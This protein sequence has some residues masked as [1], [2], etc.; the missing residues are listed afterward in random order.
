MW[1]AIFFCITFLIVLAGCGEI[2]YKSVPTTTD[3]GWTM[4]ALAD[5]SIMWCSPPPN[6]ECR[7]VVGPTR[8]P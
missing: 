6:M 2:E 3:P 8:D 5:G 7:Q 1:R 4:A